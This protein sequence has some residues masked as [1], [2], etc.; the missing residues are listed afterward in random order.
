M[1]CGCDKKQTDELQLTLRHTNTETARYEYGPSGEDI[2]L[3]GPVAKDQALSSVYCEISE[4][5]LATLTEI[6]TP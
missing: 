5:V 1:L 2:R 3:T 6:L 4:L